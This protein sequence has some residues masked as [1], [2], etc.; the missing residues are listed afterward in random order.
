MTEV[1][2]TAELGDLFTLEVFAA[3][4]NTFKVNPYALRTWK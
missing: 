1:R 3:R 4:E 2:V